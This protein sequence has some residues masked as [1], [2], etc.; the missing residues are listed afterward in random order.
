MPKIVNVF[1]MEIK[2]EKNQFNCFDYSLSNDGKEL[3][4]IYAGNLDLYFMVNNGKSIPYD[5]NV[6]ISYDITKDT[7]KLSKF[8]VIKEYRV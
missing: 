7:A 1:Y 4:V 6:S 2:R 5:E 3:K 8:N